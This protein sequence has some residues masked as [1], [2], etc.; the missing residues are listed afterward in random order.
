MAPNHLHVP[1][2]IMSLFPETSSLVYA[3]TLDHL[4]SE[5]VKL[6]KIAIQYHTDSCVKDCTKKLWRKV[7]RGEFTSNFQHQYRYV[8]ALIMYHVVP[9]AHEALYVLFYLNPTRQGLQTGL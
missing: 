5:Q 7:S 8:D 6:V 4:P 3:E 1:S 2:R 9:D